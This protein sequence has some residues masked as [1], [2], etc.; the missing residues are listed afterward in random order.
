MRPLKS[1]IS[2]KSSQQIHPKPQNGL[3]DIVITRWENLFLNEIIAE[4]K[5]DREK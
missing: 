5:L 3:R 1:D 2:F 4:E